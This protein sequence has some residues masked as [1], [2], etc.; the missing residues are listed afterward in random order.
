[1]EVTTVST[2]LDVVGDARLDLTG[3]GAGEEPQRHA[4]QVRVE[5]G[6]QTVHDGLPDP[7]GEQSLHDVERGAD[8]DDADEPGRE[9]GQQAQVAVRQGDVDDLADEER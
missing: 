8:R 7:G 3:A 5:R 1:V 9:P 6:P 2:A 4:L